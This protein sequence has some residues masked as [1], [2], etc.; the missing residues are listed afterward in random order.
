VVVVD[1]RPGLLAET[2]RLGFRLTDKQWLSSLRLSVLR[3]RPPGRA[4]SL[5]GLAMLRAALPRLVADVDTLPVPLTLAVC[6]SCR[7]GEEV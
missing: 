5:E 4:T 1:D 7:D 3:L 6:S 2:R